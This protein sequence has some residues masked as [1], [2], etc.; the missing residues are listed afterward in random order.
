TIVI[1][2]RA[3]TLSTRYLFHFLNDEARWPMAGSGQPFIT[4][5]GANEV[6]IP[7]APPAEQ[8]RIVE[9]VEALLEQVNQAK[10]RLDR[11]PLILKRFR[12]SVLAAACSGELTREWR[13]KHEHLEAPGNVSLEPSDGRSP[14]KGRLWGG[15]EVPEL[16]DD[17]RTTIPASWVWL[18][19][20]ELGTTPD[21]AVQIGPMSMKSSEF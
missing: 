1:Q 10:A 11:V 9:K 4:M 17:E 7:I 13:A 6:E 15:G 8:R 21:E 16:T 3:P 19:V 5:G 2:P 14:R 20:G 12:Q 18:K